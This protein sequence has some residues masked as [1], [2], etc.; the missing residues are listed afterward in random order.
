ME[1]TGWLWLAVTKK[2]ESHQSYREWSPQQLNLLSHFEMKMM[3]LPVDLWFFWHLEMLIKLSG[4]RWR[5]IQSDLQL[6][7]CWFIIFN[8]RHFPYIHSRIFEMEITGAPSIRYFL[9][10]SS[11]V[12]RHL[13]WAQTVSVECEAQ[14]A[15]MSQSQEAL[16]V[17]LPKWCK[18]EVTG[19]LAIMVSH[20]VYDLYNNSVDS[21]VSHF[22]CNWL[23]CAEMPRDWNSFHE[24]KFE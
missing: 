15:C 17:T 22:L 20:V 5:L 18:L 10:C 21:W 6:H 3:K 9:C 7:V 24:M 8:L 11:F 13:G 4:V 2:T 1:T 12:D 19:I 16:T 23:W 14:A